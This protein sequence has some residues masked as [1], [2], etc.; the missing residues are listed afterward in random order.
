M[1]DDSKNEEETE[2]F[3]W[4]AVALVTEQGNKNAEAAQS[5]GIE[6]NLMRRHA[7]RR[8]MKALNLKVKQKRKYPEGRVALAN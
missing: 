7:D 4:D 3:R 5:L 1:R 6:D 2:D 8:L